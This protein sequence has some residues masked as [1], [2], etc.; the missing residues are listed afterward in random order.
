MRLSQKV[1]FE[2]RSNLFARFDEK[3]RKIHKNTQKENL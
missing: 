3:L 1:I 2:R